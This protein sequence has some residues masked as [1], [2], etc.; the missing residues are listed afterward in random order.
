MEGVGPT[1]KKAHNLSKP[2]LTYAFTVVTVVLGLAFTLYSLPAPFLPF[3][4]ADRNVSS[5][6]DGV[7]LGAVSVGF[8]ISCFLTA[9]LME[10]FNYLPILMTGSGALGI[11][12]IVNSFFDRI[13]NN[14]LYIVLSCSFRVVAGIAIGLV[15]VPSFG[16]LAKMIPTRIAFVTA[17]AEAAL[18]GAQA[19]G[20][21]MGS[22]LYDAGGY[23]LAFWV[24]GVIVA[25]NVLLELTIPHVNTL[26]DQTDTNDSIKVYKDPWI[27]MAAW[28]CAACQVLL[29]FHLPTLDPFAERALGETVV[30][31]GLALLVNT[32]TTILCTPPL[33]TSKMQVM[34]VLALLGFFV[35]MGSTPILVIMID[36]Y[37]LRNGGEISV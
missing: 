32:S 2:M 17:T 16:V 28:H 29:Y 33:A 27:M 6:W 4:H 5:V 1:A 20:P 13:T 34:L 26:P 25:C 18:N 31:T 24:P 11:L 3:F 15:S 10:H 35:P 8:F 21:F 9:Q 37:K 14:I 36:V 23:S 12:F 30:W 7:I 19:F 22:L